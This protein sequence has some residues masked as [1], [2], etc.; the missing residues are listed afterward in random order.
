MFAVPEVVDFNKAVGEL[1]FNP[2][3]HKPYEIS[4]KP[5]QSLRSKQKEVRE[6]K[7]EAVV[8]GVEELHGDGAEDLGAAL[9]F[10]ELVR[11]D[12]LFRAV[13]FQLPLVK[14]SSIFSNIPPDEWMQGGLTLSRQPSI[15]P[16]AMYQEERVS[17]DY[18]DERNSEA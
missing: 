9:G 14:D 18:Q 12:S 16:L 5:A 2:R 8:K 11:G 10:P 13:D 17:N 15:K 3:E 7:S 6:P 1:L 4:R